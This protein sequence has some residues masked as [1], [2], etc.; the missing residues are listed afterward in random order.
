M[1]PG[2]VKNGIDALPEDV[3]IVVIHD[4]VRP[5]VTQEMIEESIRSAMRFQAAVLAM[6]VKE[7]I[8]MVSRMEPSSRH[9]IGNPSGRF[10]PP[11]LPGQTHPRGP[12]QGRRG[13]VSGN[14]RCFSGGTNGDKGSHPARILHQHQDY[15]P[16]RPDAG[17][18][19]PSDE[20]PLRKGGLRQKEIETRR[21]K[22]M[23][24]GFGY[25]VHR[26]VRVGR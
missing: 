14:R 23:R 16:G 1:T 11:D 24:V 21:R 3:E 6:P 8:K 22:A 26:L 4:G 25:D 13:W 5:F 18:S 17:H 7:T 12:A 9:W 15:H 19:S 10:R 20:R 2:S